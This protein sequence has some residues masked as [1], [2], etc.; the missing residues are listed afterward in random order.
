MQAFLGLLTVLIIVG[1]VIGGVFTATESSA[2][3]VVYAFIVT[4]FIYRDLSFRDL[5]QLLHNVVKTVSIV[6]ILTVHPTVG[7]DS[8]L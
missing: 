8:L 5:P 2:I 6:M 7:A 4:F 1:G 3:A